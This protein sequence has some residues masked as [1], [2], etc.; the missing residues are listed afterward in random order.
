MKKTMHSRLLL[1]LVG[2]MLVSLVV[3]SGNVGATIYSTHDFEDEA[4]NSSPDSTWFTYTTIGWNYSNVSTAD[5][6]GG[7]KSF[8]IN[9]TDGDDGH[10]WFNVTANTYDY[11]EF[12][13][14]LIN[15]TE[16]YNQSDIIMRFLDSGGNT[17]V[18]FN[19]F[20]D[21]VNTYGIFRNH[22]DDL[23]NA[24]LTNDTWY[25]FLLVFNYTTDEVQGSVFNSGGTLLNRSW[26]P[27][28]DASGDMAY[29]NFMSF[30]INGNSS[31][32]TFLYLDDF[33]LAYTW[34]NPAQA[35]NDAIVAAMSVILA[36]A[37]LL[38]IVA[39]AFAGNLTPESLV[40]IAV[41]AIIGI[42]TIGIIS[43]L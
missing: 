22:T 41:V 33:D 10:T 32:Y 12:W 16:D 7:S 36:V 9:D 43:A 23:F 26:C 11:F 5:A 8:R 15:I 3:A 21:A 25:R 17:I 40:Y 27:A 20:A 31:K 19:L 35:S 28:T 1:L 38:V 30:N 13:F 34:V 29:D 37:I 4:N 6:H 14:K 42:V 2:L 39:F 24:T 18:R